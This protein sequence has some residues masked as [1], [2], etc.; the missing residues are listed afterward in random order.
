MTITG[1]S[2]L[3]KD[4]IDRMMKEA[5]LHAEEDRQR[6]EEADVRN[7]ADS[8]VYQTER[9]LQEHADNVTE[10]EQTSITDALAKLKDALAGPDVEGVKSAT[11]ALVNVSQGFGQRLYEQA[12]Q[13]AA[14]AGGSGASAPPADDEVADAEII[15]EEQGS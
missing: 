4:E 15:D 11:E 2:A 13:S 8:L 1:Q 14:D 5:E 6:K 10:D 9:L 12:A 7:Q 3:D